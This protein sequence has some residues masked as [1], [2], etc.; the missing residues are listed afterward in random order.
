MINSV[1]KAIQVMNLFSASEPRLTLTEIARRM[2]MPK[3]TAHSMLNTL[4]SEHFI[5]KLGRD[6]YALGTAVIMLTQSVRVNV[7]L[8]DRAAPYLR[9]LAD[10]CTESVYLTIR[11]GD[12]VLYIYAI[13]SSRRLIARTAV[14]DRAHLHSTGV[15]KAILAELTP[16]EVDG[17]I[18][19]IGLPPVTS[20]STTDIDTLKDRLA[21]TRERGYS[22]DNQENELGNYCIGAAIFDDSGQV[23]GACSV[24]GTDPEIIGKR[25]PEISENIRR[26]A[27][28]ISRNMGYVPSSIS[29][30][31]SVTL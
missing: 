11:D 17:I 15:G 6:S 3:S 18:E 20:Y 26:T 24:A 19:R 31:H 7:E 29:R 21:Q 23:I 4:V 16:E 12:Y 27:L 8:R 1:L 2:N 25:A 5:E 14:G 9:E 28:I 13:E 30:L 10:Q 22:I